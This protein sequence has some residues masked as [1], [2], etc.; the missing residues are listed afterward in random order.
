MLEQRTGAVQD[1]WPELDCYGCGP[2]NDAGIRLKSYL[3]DDGRTLVATVDPDARYTSG[4]ENVAYG[5]Y[6]ASLIDCHSVWTAI[7]FAHEAADAPLEDHRFE[8]VTGSLSAEYLK[9][10]PLDE[11]LEV[12]AWIDGDLGKRVTVSSEIRAGG[13]VTARGEV[14]AVEVSGHY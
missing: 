1:A 7:T 4:A 12:R 9:P 10:T 13:E 5:G 2:A 14:V 6:L 3:A 8:Y 11:P